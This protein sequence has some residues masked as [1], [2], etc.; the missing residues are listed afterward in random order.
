MSKKWKFK[1][2]YDF[3]KDLNMRESTNNPEAVQGSHWGFY[4]IGQDAL[5]DAKYIDKNTKQWTGKN[6]INSL[7][8]FLKNPEV[9]E[10]AVREYHK[11]VWERDLKDYH[12]YVGKEIG[13]IKL[14]QAGMIAAGHLGAKNLKKFI[15]SNGAINKSDG[16]GT[17]ISEYLG[18]F[19]DERYKVDY[20]TDRLI[21]SYKETHPEAQQKAQAEI[22]STGELEDK[23]VEEMLK[24]L[25]LIGKKKIENQN[26]LDKLAEK[27]KTSLEEYENKA[28]QI[29]ENFVKAKSNSLR[30]DGE[31][32]TNQV[33]AEIQQIAASIETKNAALLA[34]KQ[35]ELSAIPPVRIQTG[36]NSYLDTN[37]AAAAQK[38]AEYESLL[39][40]YKSQCES[41]IASIKAKHKMQLNQQ[42]ESV[43]SD[44]S[45]KANI[46]KQQKEAYAKGLVSKFN[47]VKAKLS[48][49]EDVDVDN[50]MKE[51]DVS[52]SVSLSNIQHTVNQ[53]SMIVKAIFGIEHDNPILNHPEIMKEVVKK[54]NS[55]I[56]DKIIDFGAQFVGNQE[57]REMLNQVCNEPNSIEMLTML[58]G[59]DTTSVES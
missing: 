27:V 42:K 32:L 13:G 56:L 24:R 5:I 11:I 52:G 3:Y 12:Q 25:V 20:S 57:D 26:K 40:Q 51:I 21:A 46:V 38:Q 4:Q 44:I 33:N 16:L 41:Q 31:N 37:E 10:I 35:A 50:I 30:K 34:Q 47:E 45:N 2:S 39:A 55:N 49:G 22:A 28:N 19:S 14:T 17:K 23:A 48:R 53:A 9:Q 15:N 29:F 7:D 1:K 58:A 59:I 8:D 18:G 6:N 43:E 54:F 36:P